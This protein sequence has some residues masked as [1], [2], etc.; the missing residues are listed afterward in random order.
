MTIK[1]RIGLLT[2]IPTLALIASVLVTWLLLNQNS[3]QFEESINQQFVGLID[4][5]ISPLINNTLLP[6]INDDVE[7][8]QNLQN[9]IVLLLE[10]DRDVHQA[11]IAEKMS[12]VA[13]GEEAFQAADLANAENIEQAEQRMEI[14]SAEFTSE[15]AQKLYKEFQACFA[16]WKGNSREVLKLA[17]SP[18]EKAQA[19]EST[20]KGKANQTF[21]VMRE[22]IDLLQAVTQEE[23]GGTLRI[24]DDKKVAANEKENI[25]NT[26]K[27]EAI[28]TGKTIQEG[29]QNASF[30]F[31]CIGTV[32]SVCVVGLGI[33]VSRSILNPLNHVIEN[34]SSGADEI[35]SASGQISTASQ[36]L[37][38][39]T[40][41]QAAGLEE[42]SASLE[43]MSSMTKQNAQNAQQANI[44]ARE[45]RKA[46]DT[47]SES[48]GRMSEAIEDIR[49]ASDETAKII[50]V[51]DEIAF[52]TNLL[53]LNAAVE[54]ARAGEA[55]KGFAVV[56]DEVRNLA[57]RS[58]NAAKNTTALIEQSV[59]SSRNGVQICSEVQAALDQIVNS[60]AKTTDLV[61]EIAAASTE[62][63]QGIGQVNTAVTEMDQATQQNAANA[64]E[65]AST[66]EEL[67]SQA[68]LLNQ[69]VNELTA[70]V[71]GISVV[72][73]DDTMGP[74]SSHAT[75]PQAS[76]N[77]KL[78]HSG[79]TFHQIANGNKN[80]TME[81][82]E[83]WELQENF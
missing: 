36:S 4:Q 52:Q 79:R 26:E 54:A 18:G 56:A 62:Q 17:S 3:K 69:I 24:I 12:L 71:K 20:D 30:L 77:L 38:D 70:M 5:E 45:A 49:K 39:A 60:I 22:K 72:A 83:D 44:L 33:Y 2:I 40:T 51:I 81:G 74:S 64:E 73:S 1:H 23:I 11:M 58:A 37:A 6:L 43:E 29:I 19:Q 7:R 48:M 75:L 59:N 9:S 82:I 42:T 28:E 16:T 13:P 76:R 53:A 57:M 46:V 55:G 32:I 41:K 63:A 10:A 34:L 35:N 14:A 66:S 61:G 78:R 21:Q 25:V 50:K 65:S 67:T 31:V 47:G 15:K 8:L 80:E 68:R 27:E